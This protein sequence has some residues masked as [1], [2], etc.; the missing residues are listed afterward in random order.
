MRK[1]KLYTLIGLPASGKSTYADKELS[2]T[3]I[4]LS[5]DEIRKELFNDAT[6][7]KDN[8]IVFATLYERARNY[9]MQGKDVVIDATS[10]NRF[11]RAR[12]L[13]NFADIDLE[14]IAI[15]FNTPAKV[16]CERDLKRERTV[17]RDVIYRYKNKFEFPKKAEGFDKIIVIK[18][19]KMK[20][21]VLASNNKHKIEEFSQ[22]FN[23]YEILALKDIGFNDEIE[24]NGSTFFE[25]AMIKARTIS[26][27][28]K[29]KNITASVIADDSGLCVEYLNGEP[30][31]YSARYAEEHNDKANR[32]K[33]LDKLSGVGDRKAYFN[34]TLVE[35][36]P[37]GSYITC[38]G[39]TY[40]DI[41]EEEIGDTSFGYDCLFRSNELN[42]TF[43]EASSEEK[44]SVSHRGR[45][46]ESL[47][48]L[49]KEKYG[50]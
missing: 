15:F 36:F 18:G 49:R 40:G 38:D 39:K 47:K 12:V 16:C 10:I 3:A 14:R 2:K 22:M 46:I 28:M 20:K 44:N 26:D 13:S 27:F 8:D 48:K 35:L 4:I 43:G 1:P 21:I 41:T 17:G 31:I 50:L 25:N 34:C 6:H 5:S 37:D 33:L 45:A 19:D 29:A 42:K 9:L 23:D 30:G 24:E 7:Q 32:S 11:E